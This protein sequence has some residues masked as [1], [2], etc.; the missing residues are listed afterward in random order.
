MKFSVF[1]FQFSVAAL[2]GCVFVA[3]AE[4]NQPID[5]PTALKLAGAQNLDVQIARERLREAEAQRDAAIYNFFPWVTPGVGYKRHD[6]RIQDVTGNLFDTSKQQLTPGVNVEARLDLGDAWFKA[7]AAKQLAKAADHAV[8]AQQQDALTRAALGYFDLLKARAVGDVA[9]ESARIAGAYADQ[10][11]RGVELGLIFKGDALRARGQAERNQLAVQQAR[12]QQRLAAARLA[13]TLRLDPQV[14]LTPADSEL[15]PLTLTATNAALDSLVA[16]ALATRPELKQG[17][18][19]ANA[20][21]QQHSATTIGPLIPSL[22][23][24]AFVGGLGGGRNNNLDNFGGSANASLTL[25][26]RF[27]P[28]GLFDTARERTADSRMRAAALANDKLQDDITRQVVEAHT[29]VHSLRDQL[30]TLKRA[31]AT[32]EEAFRLTRERKERGL[33]VV[34][35]NIFAEQELTRARSD[36][37]AAVAAFNQAQYELHSASGLQDGSGSRLR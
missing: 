36:Y 17:A 22:G 26:W 1:S 8:E 14:N 28:G 37:V 32:A 12:E 24:Q 35:E 30:A 11:Q 31:L 29:R 15:L 34:L 10:L 18:A 25:G 2:I 6:G 19:L 33:G 5:L 21:A 20:A 16:Q 23:A 3:N 13:Q 7:L 9:A 4:T 27:G